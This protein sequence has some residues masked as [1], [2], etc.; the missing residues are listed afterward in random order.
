MTTIT[1]TNDLLTKNEYE[2][3][4][5]VK[6]QTTNNLIANGYT[7]L[8]YGETGTGK[9][10]DIQYVKNPVVISAE[11][12]LLTLNNLDIPFFEVNNWLDFLGTLRYI[13]N[14]PSLADKTI[15]IDSLSVLSEYCYEHFSRLLGGNNTLQA[16]QKLGEQFPKVIEALQKKGRNVYLIDQLDKDLDNENGS[17]IKYHPL[18]KGKVTSTKI[19]YIVDFMLV[20]KIM[21]NNEGVLTRCIYAGLDSK[22]EIKSRIGLKNKYY[23]D[24][25]EIFAE[26]SSLNKEEHHAAK[27]D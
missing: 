4:P 20:K 17:V 1:T 3:P 7:V 23:R 22:Y 19:P 25:S 14:E 13:F 15:C 2:L 10:F 11:G 8:V 16:Y 24:I 21:P 6:L 26:L 5:T 12:G 18:L 9:T 27:W